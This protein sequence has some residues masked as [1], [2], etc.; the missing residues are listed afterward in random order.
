MKPDFDVIIVGSG[1]AG[2][3]V[4]FPLVEAGLNVLMVDGG[5]HAQ[6]ELP[7]QDFLSARSNDTEQW[8]WM[9]GEN[10]RALC[11]QGAS[12]PKLRAPTLDYVFDGFS[13][14]NRIVTDNFMAVGSLATGGLSNAWGCGVAR[15]SDEELKEFPC[16]AADM[17]RSYE[18]VA[19]RIGIS[20]RSKDDLSDYFGLD[21][22]AQ[23]PIELDDVHQYLY[24][25][26][27]TQR[28]RLI[29]SG[30][31][32]GRARTAVLAEDM[33]ERQACDNYGNC[34]WGCARR[35][36]Y[37]ATEDL[38]LLR[39]HQNFR[40]QQ[41]FVVDGLVHKNGCWSVQGQDVGERGEITAGKVM[42]AAGTLATTRLALQLVGHDKSV[43]VLS[44]P[45]AAF[46]AWVPRF[47]G[48]PRKR[49]FGLGQLSFVLDLSL[50][51][52]QAFGSMFSP[53]GIPAT[54]FLRYL[55]LKKRYGVDLLKGLLSS[56][57]IGNVFLSGNLSTSSAKL[58]RDGELTIVGQYR[59]EPAL[60]MKEIS[61]KLRSTFLRLG[62]IVLPG[63]P[64]V[65]QPGG[66]IHYAGTL[67]MRRDLSLGETG[68]FGE[69]AGADGVHV[70]DGAC[71][72]T[73]PGKSHTL[74]IMANA[75]RIGRMVNHSI[76]T[77]LEIHP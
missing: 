15:L 36:L 70:V 18:T 9:I 6:V 32:I 25:R 22:W 14:A 21:D 74:T 51:Q 41:G 60:M 68:M 46:M 24:Q 45:M 29:A 2:V 38:S 72:P 57:V 52:Q 71:L 1:P 56:C 64:V 47:T 65:G 16:E 42:L 13:E 5:K 3:S 7:S 35:S 27:L 73:L 33:A 10:Y 49:M 53:Q 43:R 58:T 19:R 44:C 11:E 28:E 76:Q 30:V 50:E 12:S 63:S 8:K 69:L 26:Y 4:A 55:P 23:P 34:L 66:D 67:P 77:A 61:S 54:E 40:E 75:D 20:G 17:L 59:E 37:S 48:A 62:G 31:R 39:R